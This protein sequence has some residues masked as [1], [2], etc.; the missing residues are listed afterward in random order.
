MTEVDKYALLLKRYGNPMAAAKPF[1]DKFMT[2]WMVPVWIDTHIP[3]L[4]NKLYVNKDIIGP[5][6]TVFNR[7]I[8]LQVYKEIKTFDGLFNVRYIRGSKTKLSIHS[9]GLAIDLNASDNPLGLS[10]AQCAEKGLKPFTKLFYEIW[11]DAG[12]TCGTD[13]KRSDGMH[14]EYTAHLK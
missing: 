10:P 5:L 12:W 7:L 14:F 8:S 1:E 6:E 11:R 2:H 4:P 9:W 13:F 3:A